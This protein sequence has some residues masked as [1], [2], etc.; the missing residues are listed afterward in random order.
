MGRALGVSLIVHAIAIVLVLTAR[1]EGA[2]RT[3]RHPVEHATYVEIQWPPVRGHPGLP[4]PTQSGSAASGGYGVVNP[5]SPDTLAQASAPASADGADPS[6]VAEASSMP[7]P[8]SA[9]SRDAP[10]GTG[11]TRLGAELGDSRLIVT[12]P[13]AG[14][15]PPDDARYLAD[16]RAA[17]RAFNDSVQGQADRERRVRDWTWTDP[18]GR[19]WGVRDGV[20]F[21]AGQG[22]IYA[23]VRGERDQELSGR[24]MS[25]H[26]ADID[27]HA[28]RAERARHLQERGR[29]VRG[30]TDRE[31]AAGPP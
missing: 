14:T 10:L 27:Y 3:A 1:R 19:A 4:I 12:P 20:I 28:D 25:R 6:S 16:F 2:E 11:R 17:M 9:A 18:R 30:R 29:A 15:L 22:T 21:I 31:R 13:R 24:R 8:G 23:E 26:R 5:P 7:G